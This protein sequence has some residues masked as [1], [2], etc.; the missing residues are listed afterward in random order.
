MNPAD[1]LWWRRRQTNPENTPN[2][3]LSLTVPT[4]DPLTDMAISGAGPCLV[5][6]GSPASTHQ[7]DGLY[8][9]YAA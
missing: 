6:P 8:F 1:T 4:L 7:K 9:R 3:V 2:L 5:G